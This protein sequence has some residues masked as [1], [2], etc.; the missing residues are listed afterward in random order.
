MITSTTTKIKHKAKATLIQI[1]PEE[2][3][4]YVKNHWREGFDRLIVVLGL[5]NVLAT[6]PQIIQIWQSPQAKAISLISWVYYTIYAITLLI[7]AVLI[8]SKPMII[9]YTANTIIYLAVVVSAVLVK[10]HYFH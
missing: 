4:K 1:T 2:Y 7:Y 5:I 6:V 8:K 9:T 10:T 3:R